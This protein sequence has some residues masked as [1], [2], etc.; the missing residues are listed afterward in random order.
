[1]RHEPHNAAAGSEHT[2]MGKNN[3]N[4]NH[5]ISHNPGREPAARDA[6]RN[7]RFKNHLI[8]TEAQYIP[9]S[10]PKEFAHRSDHQQLRQHLSRYRLP[11]DDNVARSFTNA[12]AQPRDG[13]NNDIGDSN[14]DLSMHAA[15]PMGRRRYKPTAEPQDPRKIPDAVIA[16]PAAQASIAVFS[17]PEPLR[18]PSLPT[19]CR[20][21]NRRTATIDGS[22]LLRASLLH[23][24]ENNQVPPPRTKPQPPAVAVAATASVL[25]CTVTKGL[26]I[27]NVPSLPLDPEI[28]STPIHRASIPATPNSSGKI[29]FKSAYALPENNAARSK[30]KPNNKTML[31]TLDM[32]VVSGDDSLLHDAPISARASI[33]WS[34]ARSALHVQSLDA[35]GRASNSR[36]SSSFSISPATVAPIA[37]VSARGRLENNNN[38][39]RQSSHEAR[40]WMHE[41]NSVAKLRRVLCL[42]AKTIGRAAT[43][44]K[45]RPLDVF[46]SLSPSER[47]MSN[48][49][50]LPRTARSKIRQSASLKRS[51]QDSEQRRKICSAGASLLSTYREKQEKLERDSE[52]FKPSSSV[53]SLHPPV[54]TSSSGSNSI[55]PSFVRSTTPIAPLP[56]PHCGDI[57][58]ILHHAETDCMHKFRALLKEQQQPTSSHHIVRNPNQATRLKVA[59]P[60][61]LLSVSPLLAVNHAVD[62]VDPSDLKSRLPKLALASLNSTAQECGPQRS[63]LSSTRVWTNCA[64]RSTLSSTASSASGSTTSSRSTVPTVSNQQLEQ[65]L[66]SK[67]SQLGSVK[68]W[69]VLMQYIDEQYEH[70]DSNLSKTIEKMD[71]ERGLYYVNMLHKSMKLYSM[72]PRTW[73]EMISYLHKSVQA[74]MLERHDSERKAARGLFLNA[75][76]SSLHQSRSS[77]WSPEAQSVIQ[78]FTSWVEQ[79]TPVTP[80]NFFKFLSDIRRSSL[81]HLDVQTIVCAIAQICQ[82][83]DVE[84]CKWMDTYAVPYVLL[85]TDSSLQNG[86]IYIVAPEQPDLVESLHQELTL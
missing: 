4:T 62:M 69:H 17:A 70:I 19:K 71:S 43:H 35:S 86:R 49:V 48:I 68:K 72:A 47:D 52:L 41:I 9:G 66:V 58:E 67:N 25:D 65:V 12:S 39:N 55:D 80:K 63:T 22:D 60:S 73:I 74:G 57:N 14:R 7:V 28:V 23:K 13:S 33:S 10:P 79:D 34:T 40:D 2:T 6:S 11:N 8:D 38:N 54:S 15:A 64:Q 31:T 5:P 27:H 42:D 36:Q 51:I 26:S 78:R 82:V 81:L 50:P 32:S 24:R 83:S 53:E 77:G 20:T 37:P 75:F 30:S 76:L 44:I 46:R 61:D 45:K 84:L 3:N 18:S 21:A 1:M 59:D 16:A 29:S 85:S 56:R